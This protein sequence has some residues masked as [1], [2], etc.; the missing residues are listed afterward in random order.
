MLILFEGLRG[1]GRRFGSG[2]RYF[3][4]FIGLRILIASGGEWSAGFGVGRRGLRVFLIS[5]C[6]FIFFCS[7]SVSGDRGVFE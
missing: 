6:F 2:I 5:S 1:G 7:L 4:F 3:T